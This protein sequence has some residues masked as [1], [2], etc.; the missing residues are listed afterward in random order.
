MFGVDYLSKDVPFVAAFSQTNTGD[1]TPSLFAE[2]LDPK[3]PTT[4]NILNAHIIG[5][6]QLSVCK[7]AWDNAIP[8]TGSGFEVAFSHF[9]MSNQKVEARFSS[10]GKD[11]RT[12]HAIM[13]W[14]AAA[15]SL[16]DN[17][18]S[19]TWPL[20]KEGDKD[21]LTPLWQA[22]DKTEIP[23]VGSLLAGTQD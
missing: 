18:V 16:E 4:D 2:W 6:R 23:P 17:H 7:K 9:T 8:L 12:T 13:G 1:L 5:K 22:L 21:P 20:M 19:Q 15:A 10:T 11:T 3:G 14:T